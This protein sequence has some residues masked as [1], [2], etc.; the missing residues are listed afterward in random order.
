MHIINYKIV[1]NLFFFFISIVVFI[2][3]LNHGIYY[4]AIIPGLFFLVVALLSP[5]IAYLIHVFF[6][7]H[8]LIAFART[9]TGG[10][11]LI[12]FV[13][14][15]L[16]EK[17][18]LIIDFTFWILL[19]YFVAFSLSGIMNG[20]FLGNAESKG[21]FLIRIFHIFMYLLMLNIINSKERLR[22]VINAFIFFAVLQSFIVIFEYFFQL[23]VFGESAIRMEVFRPEGTQRD[24]PEG[25]M[26]LF[27]VIPFMI[28]AS[29]AHN[30]R[31]KRIV[32]LLAPVVMLALCLSSSRAYF[33][34]LITFIL[35]FLF[36]NMNIRNLKYF[37][38][39]IFFIAP[40]ML[41][42][43]S[44]V[45]ERTVGLL[46]FG[47]LTI[48]DEATTSVNLRYI[49]YQAFGL[50]FKEYPIF[51]IGPGNFYAKALEHN[52]AN[53]G[54]NSDVQNIFMHIALESGT[55]GLIIYILLLLY[56]WKSL[57]KSQKIVQEYNDFVML[58][59]IRSLK[60]AFV[61][62]VLG[63]QGAG[64]SFAFPVVISIGLSGAIKRIVFFGKQSKNAKSQAYVQ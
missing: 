38:L 33:I 9:I 59:Y 30:I 22:T 7:F 63:L 14:Y 43:K 18:Q 58:S 50:L 40:F 41:A 23:S 44:Q 64:A 52:I 56:T 16:V 4:F 2:I 54:K 39:G 57:V 35:V 24:L 15:W 61:L 20:S 42:G 21:I 11:A 26:M 49:N 34:S 13:L 51:G 25:A 62:T 27:Y 55:I 1:K 17:K 36:Y 60:Y 53:A 6:F 12:S 46:N 47:N 48:F 5:L 37:I 45:I 3:A 8:P 10:V 31:W 29:H 19:T 28:V 32:L